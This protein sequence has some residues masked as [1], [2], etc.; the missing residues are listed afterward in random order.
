MTVFYPILR[1]FALIFLLALSNRINSICFLQQCVASIFFV[2]KDFL[3]EG[4]D[5]SVSPVLVGI[6]SDSNMYLI[7]WRLFPDK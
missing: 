4:I 7:F 1:E 5:P 6:P 2:L 3:V